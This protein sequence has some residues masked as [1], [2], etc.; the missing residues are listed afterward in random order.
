MGTTKKSKA[1]GVKKDITRF[2]WNGYLW[3]DKIK[4]TVN[5]KNHYFKCAMLRISNR[6]KPSSYPNIPCGSQHRKDFIHSK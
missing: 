4:V 5:I 2:E 6:Y 1:L 3:Y